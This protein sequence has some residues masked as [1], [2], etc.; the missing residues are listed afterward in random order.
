MIE[1]RNRILQIFI[2]IVMVIGMTR[3]ALPT[4]DIT[5]L[6]EKSLTATDDSD[7]FDGNRYAK[8]ISVNE[9]EDKVLISKK[10]FQTE[11]GGGVVNAKVFDISGD[12]LSN[13]REFATSLNPT[14]ANLFFIS[15][16]KATVATGFDDTNGRLRDYDITSSTVTENGGEADAQKIKETQY[17][18]KASADM[19]IFTNPGGTINEFFVWTYSTG[20]LKTKGLWATVSS[21]Y[22]TDVKVARFNPNSSSND[23]LIAGNSHKVGLADSSLID[24]A[25][26]STADIFSEDQDLSSLLIHSLFRAEYNLIDTSHALV[27][28]LQQDTSNTAAGVYLELTSSA[29]TAKAILNLDTPTATFYYMENPRSIDETNYF[30]IIKFSAKSYKTSTTQVYVVDSTYTAA[31]PLPE[32][33]F[34]EITGTMEG[35]SK[36]SPIVYGI[37]RFNREQKKWVMLVA[38]PESTSPNNAWVIVFTL[39]GSYSPSCH[40]DCGDCEVKEDQNSCKTC[41]DSNKEIAPAAEG[42][43]FGP[44]KIPCDSS[45]QTCEESATDKA[46]KCLT[47]PSGKFLGAEVAPSS[48]GDCHEACNGCTIAGDASKCSACAT[49]YKDNSGTCEKDSPGGS[50]SGSDEDT[51]VLVSNTCGSIQIPGC[52]KCFENKIKGCERCQRRAGLEE[53]DG[54]SY[55]V[56]CPDDNCEICEMTEQGRQCQQCMS[57]FKFNS[58]KQTCWI[59]IYLWFTSLLGLILLV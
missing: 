39:S 54:V 28:P 36:A 22:G 1:K 19:C 11:Y 3:T 8:I 41:S 10:Y 13:L 44:C 50:G 12:N 30:F 51:F 56:E 24:A 45:C 5:V 21:T 55:C 2:V 20:A 42:D 32:L 17:D 18:R 34:L 33:E 57:G 59:E 7:G 4:F 6:S 58:Q 15:D 46:N 9:A 25:D 49:G 52:E 43:A 14:I 48:C 38:G 29:I 27:L 37:E 35:P 40:S 31:N 47:C 26:K 23:I 53:R 16:N